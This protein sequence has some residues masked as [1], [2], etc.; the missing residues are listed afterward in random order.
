MSETTPLLHNY[1]MPPTTFIRWKGLSAAANAP[2]GKTSSGNSPKGGAATETA[3][4][5]NGGGCWL[6]C[7]HRFDYT[8]SVDWNRCT[9]LLERVRPGHGLREAQARRALLDAMQAHL[10]ELDLPPVMVCSTGSFVGLSYRDH[11]ILD[12]PLTAFVA[13]GKCIGSLWLRERPWRLAPL[14]TPAVIQGGGTGYGRGTYWG[15]RLWFPDGVPSH[16]LD[17]VRATSTPFKKP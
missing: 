9:E 3:G 17:R 12:H 2:A 5:A 1:G 14:N 7:R 16:L 8:V 13:L 10:E 15:C 11:L 4:A 6:Y